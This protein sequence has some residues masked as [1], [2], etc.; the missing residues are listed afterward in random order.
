VPVRVCMC[1]Y[2]FLVLIVV[3]LL[4]CFVRKI[5]IR[6]TGVTVLFVFMEYTIINIPDGLLCHHSL[7]GGLLSL[8]WLSGKSQ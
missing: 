4:P 2:L 3:C 7:S 1:I 6:A 5:L 8:Y